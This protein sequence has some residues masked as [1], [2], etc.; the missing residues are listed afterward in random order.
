MNIAL[1]KEKK[2]YVRVNQSPFMNKKMSK[3]IMKRSRLR[4]KYLNTKSVIDRKAYNKQRNYVISILRN[5]KK[6]FYNNLDAKDVI[7]NRTF[8]K[9]V[10]PLLSSKVTKHSKINLV[11]D[12]KIISRD[13]QIAKSFSEYLI[14][15][16]ILH[17][18]SSGYKC[19]HYQNKILFQK[20]LTSIRTIQVLN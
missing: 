7:H 14:R 13:D 12:D 15:I 17:M 18:P 20:Y 3:E 5:E 1:K 10:K 16:P 9:T 8:W 11:E 2:R 19:P 6:N 4:K